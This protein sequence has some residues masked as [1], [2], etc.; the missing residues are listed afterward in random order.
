MGIYDQLNSKTMLEYLVMIHEQSYSQ[1]GRKL[2]ITPQQ[3][4]DWIKK[5]RPIPEER[6]KALS[7][8]FG[9]STEY[10]V[11]DNSYAGELTPIN[12]LDIQ[13]ILVHRKMEESP[14]ED[15]DV[16]QTKLYEL[17][18]EKERQI[19]IA[20]L[21]AML[22]QD[23]DNVNWII[24]KVLEQLES[25]NETALAHKLRQEGTP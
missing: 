18:K 16:Y 10:L 21:V 22:Q 7:D 17:Q 4:S 3:F 24:D 19:R 2:H 12:K 9:V 23:N 20:R 15:A 5:R 6:L 14:I 13:M 25:G 1:I 8:Y 11:D